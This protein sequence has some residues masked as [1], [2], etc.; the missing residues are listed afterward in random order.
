MVARAVVTDGDARYDLGL[1]DDAFEFVN[2]FMGAF[3]EDSM[4]NDTER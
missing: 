4:G 3:V 2:D 1:N